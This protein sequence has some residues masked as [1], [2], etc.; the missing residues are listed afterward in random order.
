M[1]ETLTIVLPAKKDLLVEFQDL[2]Q[3]SNKHVQM[4]TTVLKELNHHINFHALTELI[5]KVILA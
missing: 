3:N 1:V 5:P 4:V 2:T